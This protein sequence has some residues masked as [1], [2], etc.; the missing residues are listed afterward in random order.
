MLQSGLDILSKY[1]KTKTSS[2]NVSKT[3]VI[4]L[5]ETAYYR[6]T[7]HLNTKS[8]KYLRVCTVGG[9]FPEAQTILAGQAQKAI[10]KLHS[11]LCTF[12]FISPKHKVDLFDK[13]IPPILNYYCEGR[14]VFQAKAVERVY[15]QFCKNFWVLKSP[16]TVTL[17]MENWGEQIT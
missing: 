1:C 12:T 4:V 10:F 11:Y 7:Y 6:E 13:L 8:F 5:G 16:H 3:K 17:C 9:S 14:G 15:I 2:I